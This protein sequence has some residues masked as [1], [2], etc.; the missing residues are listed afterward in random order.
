MSIIEF[1]KANCKNCY[2]CIRECS[3]K[4]IAFKDGQVN[5]LEDECLLCGHCLTVCPQNAKKVKNDAYIVKDL[6]QHGKDV[7][8]SIAPSFISGFDVDCIEELNISLKKLG[9]KHAEETSIG[10]YVVAKEYERLAKLHNKKNI[11]TSAC[12]SVT[13]LIEKY[14]PELVHMLADCLSPME[15]H[16]RMLKKK[17]KDCA[18]VFIGPC[19][20]KKL[21]GQMETNSEYID[22]VITFEELEEWF[23]E[24]A[25]DICRKDEVA[26]EG[27]YNAS[28]LFPKSGGILQSMNTKDLDYRCVSVDGIKKCKEICDNIL[29][30]NIEG[31]FI[32]MNSCEGGCINGPCIT[33]PN[34]GM[35][36]SLGKVEEYAKQK[37]IFIDA[38][39]DAQNI[40]LKKCFKPDLKKKEVPGNAKI[41]EILAKIGKYSKEQEL[42]CGACGYA[43]CRDKAIAV[44]QGKAQLEMCLPYMFERAQNISEVI[45]NST[46]NAIIA[47]NDQLIVQ[48]VNMAAEELFSWRGIR[49]KGTEL[50]KILDPTD[51]VNV[52]ETRKNIANKKAFYP[53]HGKYVEQSIIYAKEHQL[54]YGIM[55]DIT[56]EEE[57]QKR[58]KQVKQDTVYIAGKVI[59]KQ[60]RVAQE[61]ASI[62]GETTAETKIALTKLK[63][64]I[65][66]EGD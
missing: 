62:L 31:F 22:A 34:G 40:D 11:I 46:P 19:I 2:K 59:D 64:T 25:I 16:A 17:Y 38:K 23:E 3:V 15:V 36:V 58:L 20:S 37:S 4:C 30:G 57:Q 26:E 45:I 18:V 21:E 60:M 43:S 27:N 12:P 10:A 32:E 8:C 29:S 28:V 48:H 66:Q 5:I 63:D 49:L 35:L 41:K 52:V 24:S 44:Y 9:F 54:I 53:S 65:L 13:A 1:K 51:F 42:N 56:R 14:Y 50:Q 7:V 55:K 61:I 6:I 47:V 39:N 33:K